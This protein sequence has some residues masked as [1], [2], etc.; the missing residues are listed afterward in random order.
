[1]NKNNTKEKN[2][3]LKPNKEEEFKSLY[4][5]MLWEQDN[6][7]INHH[8]QKHDFDFN[9]FYLKYFEDHPT[10]KLK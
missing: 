3:E 10:K 8:L 2:N 5:A 4:G 1:M 7:N 6:P 9:P